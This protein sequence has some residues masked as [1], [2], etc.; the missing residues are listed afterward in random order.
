LPKVSY[1]SLTY[2]SVGHPFEVC[3]HANEEIEIVC[4]VVE[5]AEIFSESG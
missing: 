2:H 5:R 1:L 3:I 4:I